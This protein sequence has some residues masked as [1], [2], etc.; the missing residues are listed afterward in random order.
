MNDQIISSKKFTAQITSRFMYILLPVTILIG[1]IYLLNKNTIFFGSSTHKENFQGPHEGIDIKDNVAGKES[2]PAYNVSYV[3]ATGPTIHV[4]SDVPYGNPTQV[5]FDVVYQNPNQNAFFIILENP[6][7]NI[8]PMII[9]H[10]VIDYLNENKAWQKI[11]DPEQNLTLFQ[12]FNTN[13]QTQTTLYARVEDFIKNSPTEGRIQTWNYPLENRVTLKREEKNISYTVAF[14]GTTKILIATKTTKL[15]F[16]LSY[17]DSNLSD[18]DDTITMRLT[19]NGVEKQ[20]EIFP[21]DGVNEDT[22]QNTGR[23]NLTF[24][25]TVPK[26]GIYEL[27]IDTST[28]IRIKEII[29][30]HAFVFEQNITLDDNT[31]AENIIVLGNFFSASTAH[32]EGLQTINIQETPLTLEKQYAEYRLNI[33]HRTTSIAI[34]KADVQITTD[35][36][37]GFIKE[38]VEEFGKVQPLA[39]SV[40]EFISD[41]KVTAVLVHT[42]PLQKI[43]KGGLTRV[44]LLQKNF[45][46]WVQEGK[47]PLTLKLPGYD[48]NESFKIREIIFSY[49]K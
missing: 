29:T 25:T 47:F 6:N 41:S 26:S 35:G 23:K 46:E 21:D 43:N 9:D 38:S 20:K 19:Q 44:R 48:K 42:P 1:T 30:P 2:N 5:A 49:K 4:T 40:A 24:T 7:G 3:R 45:S 11:E 39:N 31:K 22:E 12:K 18:G 15:Q 16:Q 10:P 28:D 8:Q 13:S 36:I 37:I 32:P 33:T 17:E 14:R 34:E 27:N